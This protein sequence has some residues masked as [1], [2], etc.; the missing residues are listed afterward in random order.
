MVKKERYNPKNKY[1]ARYRKDVGLWIPQR[2]V[3][4]LY[5]YKYLQL[6][7]KEPKRKVNWS[8]YKGWGGA[9][10]VLGMKFDEWWNERWQ[11]LFGIK[12]WSDKPKFETSTRKPKADA[13]RYSLRLYEN[14]WRGSKWELAVWFKK[15]EKRM[16]FLEFFDKIDENKKI[17]SVLKGNDER[18]QIYDEWGRDE[19]RWV[20]GK[21][22]NYY[23][24]DSELY[25]NRIDRGHVQSVIGRYLRNAN[26]Y[27]SNVCEGQFP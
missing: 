12:E 23:D 14:K 6:A 4:Y 1:R 20:G 15:N 7:E 5:W 19:K 24:T 10:V 11:D 18:R 25:L 13:L 22:T 3:I 26:K 17:G 27:I 8:K 21:S 16:Y 9:N 2:K